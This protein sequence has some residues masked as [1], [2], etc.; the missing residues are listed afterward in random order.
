[1]CVRGGPTVLPTP[2]PPIT[3]ITAP[4]SEVGSGLLQR[5]VLE[6]LRRIL[7]PSYPTVISLSNRKGPTRQ[8][9]RE[10]RKFY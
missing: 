5:G 6:I 4:L 8:R 7:H 10:G 2:T 1:M 9:G 3:E